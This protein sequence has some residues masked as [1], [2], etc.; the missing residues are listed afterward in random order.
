MKYLIK[1]LFRLLGYDLISNYQIKRTDAFFHIKHLLNNLPVQTIFDVGA[2]TGEFSI[3]FSQ[4]FTTAQIHSFEPQLAFF[5]I[6]Q[7][8]SQNRWFSNMM[9]LSNKKET[10]NF[11]LTSSRASSSL[12][13]PNVTN[14]GWDSY[15]NVSDTIIVET[16]TIENYCIQHSIQRINLLKIDAQGSELNILKGAEQMLREGNIDVIY[17][18]VLFMP[19]Y[20][21]QPLFHDIA[22]FLELYNYKL[23]NIYDHVYTNNSILT[24]AD[25]IFVHNDLFQNKLNVNV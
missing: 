16:N 21:D 5:S 3:K 7:S 17:T 2:A 6:L 23:Y 8:N 15:L 19:F 14:T 20:K 13:H 9:A 18:E 10:L 4:L 25:A 11:Y 1:R 24:W 12:F 22:V